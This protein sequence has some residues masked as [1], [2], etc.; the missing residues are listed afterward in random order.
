MKIKTLIKVIKINQN[1]PQRADYKFFHK[2][3]KMQLK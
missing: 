2:I 1:N 3:I